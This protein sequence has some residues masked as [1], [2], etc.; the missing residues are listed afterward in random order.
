MEQTTEWLCARMKIYYDE[1]IWQTRE[2]I[3]YTKKVYPDSVFGFPKLTYGKKF[4][5]GGAGKQIYKN[6]YIEDSMY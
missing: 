1:C 6:I 2:G 3:N 5:L 4:S